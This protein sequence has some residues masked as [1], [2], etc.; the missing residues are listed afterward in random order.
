[1][2]FAVLP[3]TDRRLR[4]AA[5]A[6]AWW[7]PLRRPLSYAMAALQAAMALVLLLTPAG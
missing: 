1:M 4:T 7:A 6:P 2:L 3:P 5:S